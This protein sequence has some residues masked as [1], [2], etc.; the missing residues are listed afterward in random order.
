MSSESLNYPRMLQTALRGLVREALVE[1]EEQGMP[2]EHHFYIQFS[3]RHPDL[4]IPAFLLEQF[5][6]EMTIILQHQFWDLVVEE[7]EFSVV[8]SF[9]GARH[10]LTIPFDAVTSFADPSVRFA[11]AIEEPERSG[12]EKA[13]EPEEEPREDE[14]EDS[15]PGAEV[16]ELDAFRKPRT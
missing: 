2:G 14:A 3:T 11:L 4:R 13:P 5:P 12:A 8:L 10:G 16:V 9:G 7:A 6:D 15:G 1:V